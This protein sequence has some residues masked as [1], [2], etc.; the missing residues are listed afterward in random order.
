MKVSI[1]SDI[2]SVSICGSISSLMGLR[3]RVWIVL[4]F[5]LV[6]IEL[7]C[8]VKV[9]VVWLVMRIVVSSMVNLWRKE[10]IIRLIV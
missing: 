4:I 9:L 7:I 8:V 6:F 5:L 2:S 10:N 1:G 3:L